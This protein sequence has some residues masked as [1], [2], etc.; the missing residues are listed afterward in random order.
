MK[1]SIIIEARLGSKRLPNKIIYRIKKYLFL[2]YLIKRLK[3]S[4]TI[5][6]IIIA[7][8]NLPQDNKIVQIAKKNKIKF[9]RGSENNVLKRVIDTAKYFKCKTI[10]RVTSDCPIIDVGIIDQAV[11]IFKFN[12]CDYLSNSWIRGYP[13]GMDIEI[14]ELKT[15]IKSYKLAKTKRSREWITWSIRKNPK[16][17]SHINLIPPQELYWPELCLTLDEYDDYLLLKKI[18]LHFKER[19]DFNCHDV[20]ELLKDKKE[21]QKINKNVVR[22]ITS[23]YKNIY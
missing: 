12:E 13:D 4:K 20:I 18:I 10:A 14:F 19:L 5:N 15:L 22:K 16:I 3:Q 8:T 9:Y 23:N 21:W 17:F 6:E 7:T 11:Q 2:E 1:V